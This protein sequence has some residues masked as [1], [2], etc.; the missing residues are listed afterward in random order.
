MDLNQIISS[1]GF[2]LGIVQMFDQLKTAKKK[3]EDK[4]MLYLTLAATVL[5]AVY[6]FRKLGM[7]FTTVYTLI[8]LVVQIYVLKQI[9]DQD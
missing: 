5:W 9:L 4:K 6:Q 1:V 2:S 8:G 7:Q 3:V